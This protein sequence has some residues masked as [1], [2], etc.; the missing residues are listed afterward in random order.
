[1]LPQEGIYNTLSSVRPHTHTD[2]KYMG[3]GAMCLC[4]HVFA[5]TQVER[6]LKGRVPKS[7]AY[8]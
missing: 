2:C 4:V 7:D 1:M 5:V 8:L 3:V 6:G